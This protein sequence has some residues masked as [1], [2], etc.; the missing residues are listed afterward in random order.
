MSTEDNFSLLFILTFVFSFL[1]FI[2]SYGK[3][4]TFSFIC[5]MIAFFLFLGSI[6]RWVTWIVNNK[7]DKKIKNN[8]GIGFAYIIGVI[9]F[10]C[11]LYYI[12]LK[13]N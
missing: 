13:F 1:G 10:C 8:I 2:F 11:I 5:C 7:K 4:P 9:L 12:R 6:G 3:D